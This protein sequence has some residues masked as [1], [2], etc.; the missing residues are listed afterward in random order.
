M[1]DLPFIERLLRED[2]DA[3]VSRPPSASSRVRSQGRIGVRQDWQRREH[4][5]CSWKRDQG[6]SWTGNCRENFL[7]LYQTD[8]AKLGGRGEDFAVDY[9][10][11]REF[12][13]F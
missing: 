2:A 4:R 5:G 7:S 3:G 12:L 9:H 6:L 1:G 10:S 13:N 11:E 8:R